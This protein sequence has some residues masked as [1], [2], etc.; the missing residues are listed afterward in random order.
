MRAPRGPG[1]PP[2]MGGPVEPPRRSV[3]PKQKRPKS[4]KQAEACGG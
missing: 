2:F 4:A 3:L 1:L